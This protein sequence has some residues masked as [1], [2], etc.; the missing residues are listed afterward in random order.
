M[1][2]QAKF[3]TFVQKGTVMNN[4]AHVFQLLSRLRQASDHPYLVSHA[5]TTGKDELRTLQD[6]AKMYD[7]GEADLCG[8]CH[9]DIDDVAN[10]AVAGCKHTFHRDCV[11]MHISMH[12]DALM[13]KGD[14]GA[15]TSKKKKKGAAAAANNKNKKAAVTKKRAR[16]QVDSDEE[17]DE[18]DGADDVDAEGDD[19]DDD[20]EPCKCPVCY[21]KLTVTLKLPGIEDTAGG[22]V[23]VVCMDNP[24]SALLMPCG[25]TAL[26]WSCAQGLENKTCPVCREKIDKIV[27]NVA[28]LTTAMA[29]TTTSSSSSSAA[30]TSPAPAPPPV[31]KKPVFG[32]R[33]IMQRIDLSRFSSSSKLDAV[34]DEVHTALA[35]HASNKVIVFS[36]FTNFL[37]IVQWK[38]ERDAEG[39]TKVV[40][41]V[42][43]LN[44]EERRSVLKA[45]KTNPKVR[46]I[47][48]SL[49]AGG[50]GLN[51]QEASH[52]L[53]CDVWWNY[54]VEAQAF[55]RAHRIGQTRRVRAV[56]FST[57]G[58]IEERMLELQ[59]KKQVLID[60]VVENNVASL[61]RL[62]EADLK[63]LFG[64]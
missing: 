51:L 54:G 36:Q 28:S 24:R 34:T 13:G 61:E 10:L 47:L 62:T 48:M 12:E 2:T 64:H 4:Y 45:F 50:E 25:H 15:K 21:V 27:K 22:E 43:A 53:S 23:C 32:R 26:C 8:I 19:D 5:D 3:D 20:D 49:K 46:V 16:Q 9:L 1:R 38:L 7:D 55:H 33:S 11:D 17:A 29:A 42:G 57:V 56:R 6:K 60:G 14:D 37:D 30:T 59:Q 52:V 18:V 58:T 44:M 31:A 39:E 40:K 63:F 41:L 35:E